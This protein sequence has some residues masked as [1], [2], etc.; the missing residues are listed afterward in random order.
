MQCRQPRKP[1]KMVEAYN[2]PRIDRKVKMVKMATHPAL[3][4][5]F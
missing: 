4:L 2:L 5:Y 1:E 3:A